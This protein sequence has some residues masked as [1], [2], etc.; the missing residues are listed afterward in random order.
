M[1]I[2]DYDKI[3]NS[4]MCLLTDNVSVG[5]GFDGGAVVRRGCR[6]EALPVETRRPTC[7]HALVNNTCLID[8]V[9]VVFFFF[10]A[11]NFKFTLKLYNCTR[12][13]VYLYTFKL[14][15]TATNAFDYSI[16]QI[17]SYFLKFF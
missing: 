14:I 4:V 17:Q 16:C 6:Y 9:A 1:P 11:H 3:N 5:L 8:Y 15:V 10:G 12:L 2:S 13:N 7:Y